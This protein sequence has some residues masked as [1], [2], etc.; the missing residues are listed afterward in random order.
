MAQQPKPN[1][2]FI[3]TDQHRADLMSCVA[4]EGG[5]RALVPT[6]NIDRIAARGVRFSHAYCPYPVCLASRSAMLTGLYPHHTGAIDNT[7]RLDWRYRTMAHHFA[8]AGYLTALIGKMHYNDAHNHGFEY[9]MSINDWL[10]V[11]GPK[12][13]HYADEIASHQLNEGFYRTV[14]DTGAGFPDLEGMWDGPSPWVGQVE[15][16]PYTSVTSKLDAED[17]LDA[18]V[19]RESCKFMQR[20]RD[21]PF[22]LLTSF[23]KPHTP[24]FP[25]K[26]W[27][28]LYPI[29]EIEL[30]PVGDV[31]SYPPHIQQRIRTIQ[32]VGPQRLRA[33]RAGYLGNLAYV[34]TCIGQVY[35]ALHELGLAENTIVVYTSDHGEMLGDHGLYQK[36]CLFEGAVRVPLIVS[37]P[38][39]LPEGRVTGAL[40]ELIGV[41]P[42]LAE[43]AGLA[44]PTATTQAAA[45]GL[46]GAPGSL[47]GTS[48]AEIARHPEREGPPAVF[49]EYNL[50][51]ADAR[52]MIRTRRFKYVLNE[53]APDDHGACDELYDLQD[54]PGEHTNR[55]DDPALETVRQDL[56]DQLLAWYDPALNPHRSSRKGRVTA[57]A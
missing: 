49:C 18:F 32:R 8:D 42:T 14:Y 37:H 29:D 3:M 38:G 31:S 45:A 21:Q 56:R 1:I 11:L 6:P 15:R 48:F 46:P 40:T 34:D 33:Q 19:A 41:Y 35:D 39:H 2:L 22:F 55:V 28:E 47:D 50:H 26:P 13:R 44:P 30:P 12:V 17:H 51:A 24:F 52:Y 53:R 23:M 5:G 7:D 20:Y 10:M 9:Y 54:D 16:Y 27:S 36:F 4:P 43:L 57:S 25:P